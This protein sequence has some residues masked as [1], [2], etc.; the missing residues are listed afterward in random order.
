MVTFYSPGSFVHE[1]TSR[2]IDSWDVLSAVEMAKG[3]TERYGAK[4]YGFVFSTTLGHDPIPDGRGGCLEVSS[5]EL[6]TSGT[7]FLGGRIITL[8]ELLA[9]NVDGSRILISNMRCNKWYAV[10]ENTNS[11]RTT[12]PFSTEDVL[13]DALGNVVAR[14]EDYAWPDGYQP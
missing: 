3:I 1:Q 2:L 5:R 4:P 6:E 7:Y 12:L 13:L 8:P 11:Y 9:G 14:G 10:V